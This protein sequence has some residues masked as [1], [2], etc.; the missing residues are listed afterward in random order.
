MTGFKTKQLRPHRGVKIL[1]RKFP[2]ALAPDEEPVNT[3]G[4]F[5]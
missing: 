3:C 4:F 5:P 2:N 1:Q